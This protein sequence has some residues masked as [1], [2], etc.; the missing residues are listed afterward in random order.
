M[1]SKI[2][3]TTETSKTVINNNNKCEKES[4]IF[5]KRIFHKKDR[6][7]DLI[8]GILYD[9]EYLYSFLRPNM[10]PKITRPGYQSHIEV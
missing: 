6:P 2:L 10:T 1:V 5:K 8:E 3:N 7:D 4:T 9:M